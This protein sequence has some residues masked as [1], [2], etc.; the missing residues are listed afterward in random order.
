MRLGPHYHNFPPQAPAALA[1][2]R[3]PIALTLP[4]F[5]AHFGDRGVR[6][7]WA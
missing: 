4:E 5:Y 1:K 6:W 3:F 7:P 2:L